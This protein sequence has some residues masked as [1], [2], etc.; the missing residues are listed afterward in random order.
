[1]VNRERPCVWDDSLDHI[2]WKLGSGAQQTGLEFHFLECRLPKKPNTV[3]YGD[4]GS[5]S[6]RNRYGVG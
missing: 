3:C 6:L 1:M 2:W 4:P 5:N